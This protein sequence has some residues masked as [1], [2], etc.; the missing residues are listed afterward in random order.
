MWVNVRLITTY[1][2]CSWMW[3]HTY[4]WLRGH[5]HS[6]C[7]TAGSSRCSPYWPLTA[8]S[9]FEHSPFCSP[10]AV[11]KRI[12]ALMSSRSFDC[13]WRTDA[14]ENRRVRRTR[15]AAHANYARLFGFRPSSS[16]NRCHNYYVMTR[17]FLYLMSSSDHF[18][19][20]PHYF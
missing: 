6:R 18:D 14:V 2:A 9:I 8:C 15:S 10:S 3:H 7:T 5:V 12:T 11:P 17:L 1:C 13:H 19:L 20:V 4:L 16:P